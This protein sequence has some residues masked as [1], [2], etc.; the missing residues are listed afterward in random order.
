MDP[1]SYEIALAA[2]Q[3]LIAGKQPS[4]QDL[5]AVV[6]ALEELAQQHA[7][8]GEKLKR[9]EVLSLLATALRMRAELAPPKERWRGYADAYEHAKTARDVA[10]EEATEA[11]VNDANLGIYVRATHEAA[12]AALGMGEFDASEEGARL[13]GEAG[14]LF[15]EAS[16]GFHRL[17]RDSDS[18]AANINALKARSMKALRS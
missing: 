18:S 5:H 11:G 10:V 1:H 13:L 2:L 6:T 4:A 9:A 3:E 7:D 12:H 16:A 14:E 17:R 8:T 15:A